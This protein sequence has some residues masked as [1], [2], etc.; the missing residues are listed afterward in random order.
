MI[1]I[2]YNYRTSGKSLFTKRLLRNGLSVESLLAGSIYLSFRMNS[3]SKLSYSIVIETDNLAT[4][5]WVEFHVLLGALREQIQAAVEAGYPERPEVIFVI[6]GEPDEE[7]EFEDALLR[8]NSE[9]G[10]VANLRVKAVRNWR[11]YELKNAGSRA[12]S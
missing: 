10:R 2:H 4:I 9:L 3:P 5:S 6:A 11:Y 8:D 7:P 12:A 1:L